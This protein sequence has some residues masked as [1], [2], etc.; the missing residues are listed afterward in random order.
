M[1]SRMMISRLNNCPKDSRVTK[2]AL[3]PDWPRV[4]YYWAL[5]DYKPFRYAAFMKSIDDVEHSKRW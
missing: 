4:N 5:Q 2:S 3:H 1:R